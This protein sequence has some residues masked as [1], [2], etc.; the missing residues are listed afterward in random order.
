MLGEAEAL[1]MDRP[2]LDLTW[3]YPTGAA[4]RAGRREVLAEI[5]GWDA[6]GKPLSSYTQLKSDGST[7]CGCWI[8]CGV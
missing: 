2:V 6:D 5:N 8:Y 1:D 3:D 4:G 7:S